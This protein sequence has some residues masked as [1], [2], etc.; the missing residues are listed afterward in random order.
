MYFS[1]RVLLRSDFQG[2]AMYTEAV[3]QRY[4]FYSVGAEEG[5]QTGSITNG[6]VC[7]LRLLTLLRPT[8]DSKY[9]LPDLQESL[10]IHPSIEPLICPFMDPSTRP[11]IHHDPTKY[12]SNTF[13]RI[14]EI[15]VTRTATAV[16][17]AL[18]G[19]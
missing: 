16:A 3:N 17:N 5:G 1:F 13:L 19:G 15:I 9:Q 7:V 8:G 14:L 2:G 12:L 18:R 11:F 10:S 4:L 6:A